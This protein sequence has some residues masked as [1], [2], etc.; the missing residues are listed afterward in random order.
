MNAS[1]RNRGR[2]TK[3]HVHLCRFSMRFEHAMRQCGACV[4]R[5]SHIFFFI[6]VLIENRLCLHIEFPVHFVWC[7]WKISISIRKLIIASNFT[8]NRCQFR[9]VFPAKKSNEKLNAEII[10][11][12]TNE[13]MP[14]AIL[15]ANYTHFFFLLRFSFTEVCF[16]HTFGTSFIRFVRCF[17][18]F[19]KF[20]ISRTCVWAH[21]YIYIYIYETRNAT[22]RGDWLPWLYECLCACEIRV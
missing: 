2:H 22:K 11:H 8:L 15:F 19:S 3:P 16:V 21:K 4:F 5:A 10:G 12:K 1:E 17:I 13:K 9:N 14:V 6:F 18:E 20:N 7:G